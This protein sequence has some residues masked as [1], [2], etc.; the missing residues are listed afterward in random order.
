MRLNKKM[1]NPWDIPVKKAPNERLVE[2]YDPMLARA[3]EMVAQGRADVAEWRAKQ[4][5][6][7]QPDMTLYGDMVADSPKQKAAQAQFDAYMKKHEAPPERESEMEK[8][9][10]LSQE[11][12]QRAKQLRSGPNSL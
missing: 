10:R 11:A 6:P 5:K 9:Y 2:S 1:G 8:Q 3:D 12:I 4:P 7:V